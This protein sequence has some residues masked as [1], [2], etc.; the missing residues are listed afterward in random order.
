MLLLVI[1]FVLLGF[2][3]KFHL[4]FIRYNYIKVSFLN[5]CKCV[6]RG[7]L[8]QY[9]RHSSLMSVYNHFEHE[10][11]RKAIIRERADVHKALKTMFT[12][13]EVATHE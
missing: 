5:T 8:N 9:N 11:F 4:R 1:V 12:K 13:L 3:V 10:K 6:Y 7:W 2:I